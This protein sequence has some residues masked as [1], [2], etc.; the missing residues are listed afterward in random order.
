MNNY[1][2]A[3][4]FGKALFLLTEEV[5]TTERVYGESLAVREIVSES[6]E[7]LKLLDTPALSTDERLSLIDEAFAPFDEH[8]VNAIKLLVERRMAYTIP[9]VL[10]AYEDEYLEARG[11]VRAEAVTAVPLTEAQT[12]ALKAR[13]ESIT[14]KVI[15]IKNK[16]D[17]SILGGIK[18][19]Y[20]GIQRDGS[21]RG[22]LDDIRERLEN[23]A[24]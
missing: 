6:P 5:G 2:G 18:L 12:A 21:V 13:L 10:V 3:I 14:G 11:I 7:Y 4:E 24:I 20:M 1:G 8:L 23:T 15:I 16:I 17:P 19:R 9:R 22:R